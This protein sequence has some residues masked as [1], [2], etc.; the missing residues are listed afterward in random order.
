MF[1][2]FQNNAGEQAVCIPLSY[3]TGSD[4]ASLILWDLATGEQIRRFAGHRAGITRV[5]YGPAGVDGA[6]PALFSAANDSTVIQWDPATETIVGDEQA[7][8]FAARTP[9]PGFE[10]L[11]VGA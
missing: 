10:I 11:D 6:A 8:S 4:D 5:A 3:S 2:R 1:A 9:R 7:A